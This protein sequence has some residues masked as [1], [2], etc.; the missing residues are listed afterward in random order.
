MTTK[1]S[2]ISISY[3][4]IH[5]P[6]CTN[7]VTL[8]KEPK[9]LSTLGTLYVLLHYSATKAEMEKFCQMCQPGELGPAQVRSFGSNEYAYYFWPAFSEQSL[10]LDMSCRG[11]S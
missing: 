3:Y 7:F 9:W 4:A 8:A 6:G 10:L 11:R 2:L 5:P 1:A